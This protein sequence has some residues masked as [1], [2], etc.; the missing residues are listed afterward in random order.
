MKKKDVMGLLFAV[1]PPDL[2]APPGLGLPRFMR[3][4]RSRADL[5]TSICCSTELAGS[6]V[7][8]WRL[9]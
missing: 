8:A 7:G 4:P 5:M 6:F 1:P 9:S 2:P 3:A